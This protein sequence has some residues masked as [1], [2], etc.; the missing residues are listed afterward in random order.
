MDYVND[1]DLDNSDDIFLTGTYQDSCDFN[2]DG[3]F[4]KMALGSSDIYLA[5]YDA[6][7]GALI[8]VNSMG[9][10]TS[11]GVSGLATDNSNNVIVLGTF[12]NGADFDEDGIDDLV[13][14]GI[15]SD[16]FIAKY[17]G[18]TGNLINLNQIDGTGIINTNKIFIDSNNRFYITGQ[19]TNTVDFDND[20]NYDILSTGSYDA[21]VARFLPN[22][23]L[24]WA[25]NFGG[26]DVANT[27]DV[28]GDNNGN[29]YILGTWESNIEFGV[30]AGFESQPYDIPDIFILKLGEYQGVVKSVFTLHGSGY[31]YPKSLAFKGNSLYATGYTP[32]P[33]LKYGDKQVLNLLNAYE[34]YV[35]KI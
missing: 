26:Y 25:K 30:Y 21:Y 10:T 27:N 33:I 35:I 28:I 8:W 14:S 2:Q 12:K 13:S 32:S 1:M 17:S 18:S 11:D 16:A 19:M 15:S 31:D 7:N 29:V 24:S 22:M 23:T 9:G 5:K 6:G 4:E 3:I 20:G 34:I